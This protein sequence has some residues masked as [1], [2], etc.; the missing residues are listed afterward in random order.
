MVGGFFPFQTV[1]SCRKG[2]AAPPIRIVWSNAVA[3]KLMPRRGHVEE[4]AAVPALPWRV[5]GMES[6]KEIRHQKVHDPAKMQPPGEYLLTLF[7][8]IWY[9]DHLHPSVRG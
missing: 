6:L 3:V 1:G 8:W 9:H 4:P 7:L 2:A 5:S